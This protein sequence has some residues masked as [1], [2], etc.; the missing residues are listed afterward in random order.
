MAPFEV[1]A[2]ITLLQLMSGICYVPG[3]LPSI[4]MYISL[5]RG[6][7]FPQPGA[8]S[9]QGKHEGAWGILDEG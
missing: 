4:R 9:S 7:R 2:F 1:A 5:Q 6:G 8:E 3:T